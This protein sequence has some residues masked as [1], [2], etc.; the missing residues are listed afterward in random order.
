ME[1][2]LGSLSQRLQ[3]LEAKQARD[4]ASARR[5]YRQGFVNGLTA[6]VAS[7]AMLGLTGALVFGQQ[8]ADSLFVDAQ[9]RVGIGTT[10]PNQA[11]TVRHA[12]NGSI[13]SDRTASSLWSG[14]TLDDNGVNNERWFVGMPGNSNSL[15]WRNRAANNVVTVED[16]AQA[17]QLYLDSTGKIGVGIANPVANLDIQQVP[18]IAAHPPSVPGL[19]V[20][21]DFAPAQGVEFR[22]T[23]GTQGIGFGYNTIY[24][25]GINASQDLNLSARGGGSMNVTAAA[26]NMNGALRVYGDSYLASLTTTG[27][28]TRNDGGT[29]SYEIAPRYHLSLTASTYDGR[30]KAIPQ[31]VVDRLCGDQDGCEVRLGMTHWN[32]GTETE[33]ASVSFLF[34]YS[35]GDGRWR[36]SEN[37]GPAYG[38]DGNSSV[39]HA[40]NA[41]NTCF[42]TDG[43]YASYSSSNDNAR[44][45][46][47]LLW[48][49]WKGGSRTCELTLID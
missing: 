34:Y 31:D 44:G 8:A 15:I 33:T 43:A 39:Q 17:N 48:N 14:L 16:N 27:R 7:L 25:T 18:R 36:S 41:F 21:G 47:L 19:Y 29:T 38:V 26:M 32:D 4:A 5:W 37:T 22:H 42:F 3:E 46:N 10:T 20:T 49:G 1:P 30:S 6:G 9:G 23:N 40:G 45:M 11:L 28:Y 24:A 13:T 2:D 12:T 35:P